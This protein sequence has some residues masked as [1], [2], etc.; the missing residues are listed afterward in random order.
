MNRKEYRIIFLAMGVLLIL[1]C[2]NTAQA[3][4]LPRLFNT[5]SKKTPPTIS[6]E[7][8]RAFRPSEGDLEAA[9]NLRKSLIDTERAEKRTE[10]QPVGIRPEEHHLHFGNST[11]QV[12]VEVRFIECTSQTIAPKGMLPEHGWVMLPITQ[13]QK[14]PAALRVNDFVQAEGTHLGTGAL[15]VTEQYTPTLIRF[16]DTEDFATV[17][18]LAQGDSRSNLMQAPKITM[19]SGQSG[20]ISDVTDRYYAWLNSRNEKDADIEILRDGILLHCLVEV[21]ED[22]SVNMKELQ[23]TITQIIGEEHYPLDPDNDI[24]LTIPKLQ[25]QKFN[26]SATIPAGK[27]LLVAI[28]HACRLS[29]EMRQKSKEDKPNTLCLAVTCQVIEQDVI[30]ENEQVKSPE[31]ATRIAQTAF[32]SENMRQAE[33]EWRRF[34]M[35]DKTISR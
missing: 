10:T 27:T 19:F 3:Q 35:N 34:M 30:A 28:P 1:L 23:T 7:V 16:I 29:E 12:A 33:E 9:K 17:C 21:A 18:R 22:G 5:N 20:R 2:A 25:T 31:E 8:A 11:P 15:S 14:A 32:D 24:V 13:K 26:L 4:I 6:P